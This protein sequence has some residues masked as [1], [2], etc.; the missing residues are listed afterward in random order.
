MKPTIVKNWAKYSLP[1]KNFILSRVSDK[2]IAD[3]ILQDVYIK[4]QTHIGSLKDHSKVESWIYQ[5]ARNTIIDHYRSKRILAEV[6]E[7]LPVD[8]KILEKEDCKT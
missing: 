4:A 1:L 2:S 6:P 5:I 8:E 7:D 3:D